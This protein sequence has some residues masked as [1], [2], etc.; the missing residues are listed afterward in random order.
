MSCHTRFSV[1]DFFFEISSS[2][3]QLTAVKL[4]VYYFSVIIVSFRD[5]TNGYNGSLWFIKSGDIFFQLKRN[6]RLLF[7]SLKTLCLL[8]TLLIVGWELLRWRVQYL[9][10][11][12][13]VGFPWFSWRRLDFVQNPS[14]GLSWIR[15]HYLHS[16]SWEVETLAWH[17]ILQV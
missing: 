12:E 13:K 7:I 2:S 8:K 1:R 15:S 10:F 14:E 17:H 11:V 6:W 4:P 16:H 9:Y 3:L 5:R